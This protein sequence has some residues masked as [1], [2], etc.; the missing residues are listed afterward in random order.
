MSEPDVVNERS[1]AIVTL[2]FK[3][4]DGVN[5]IPSSGAYRLTDLRSNTMIRNWTNL[6]APLAAIMEVTLTPTD[7]RIVD[8]TNDYEERLITVQWKYGTKYGTDDYTIRIRNLHSVTAAFE[9]ASV[10]ASVSPSAGP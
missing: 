6:V 10:S 2:T 5:A 3:D 4:E 7:T 1:S 8:S 9:T